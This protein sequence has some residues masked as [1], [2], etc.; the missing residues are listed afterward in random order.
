MDGLDASA[1]GEAGRVCAAGHHLPLFLV[2]DISEVCAA[3]SRC[4]AVPYPDDAAFFS[5][6]IQYMGL[7]QIIIVDSV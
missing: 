1:G 6:D 5:Q 2:I 3:R 4:M 7:S